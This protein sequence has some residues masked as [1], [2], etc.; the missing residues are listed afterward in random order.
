[1]GTPGDYQDFI[2]ATVRSSYDAVVRRPWRLDRLD[3]AWM[4]KADA[5][6]VAEFGVR[7]G[8]TYDDLRAAMRRRAR[9]L[10]WVLSALPGVAYVL[11]QVMR[12]LFV[13]KTYAW[14]LGARYVP[15]PEGPLE[16]RRRA[17]ARPGQPAAGSRQAAPVG[18]AVVLSHDRLPYLKTTLGSLAATTDR[19][20]LEIIVVDNGSKD[21]SAEYLRGLAESGTIDR[22]ILR[23]SN[24]GTSP[25][26]NVGF[27]HAD[28]RS[29]FLIKLDSDIVLLTPG[30]LERFETF[31]DAHPR[32]GA[33]A[34][35]QINHALLRFAPK[36]R[37]GDEWV[38]SWNWFVCGGAC[39]TIPRRVF[40]DVGW[41]NEE[42]SVPYMPDDLDYA[43]RLFYLGY[44]AY[45]LQGC[46]TYHR[47]DLDARQFRGHGRSKAAQRRKTAQKQ[48]VAMYRAYAGGKDP[49]LRY[50]RY[51]TSSVP[52]SDRILSID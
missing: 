8:Q 16:A 45:Y 10:L 18:S 32:V 44:E 11:Y 9:N 2:E 4:L 22:L 29:R 38:S 28:R 40:D 42:F 37:L 35:T 49:R 48:E 12:G 27:A 7:P 19:D 31:L 14:F 21:G 15:D 30:W 6:G 43:T 51:A 13:W 24:H 33:V 3:R 26:F 34:Q 17:A 36:R 41:L 47:A 50:E 23:S 39:M 1:M 46:I 5:R 25:G 20:R 52:D